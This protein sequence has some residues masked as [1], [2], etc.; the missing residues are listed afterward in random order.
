MQRSSLAGAM[1]ME[2]VLGTNADWTNKIN[3]G[4]M[5]NSYKPAQ[6]SGANVVRARQRRSDADQSGA[7]KAG[8]RRA[9]N[10]F[11]WTRGG[12]VVTVS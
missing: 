5:P 7:D 10:L 11:V 8:L 3:Q 2:A 12:H 6:D 4:F 1:V 9:V